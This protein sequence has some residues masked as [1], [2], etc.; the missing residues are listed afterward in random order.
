MIYKLVVPGPVTDVEEVRILEWHAVIGEEI[1]ANALLV[2][3]ETHK[4]VVEVR[5][6]RSG[7]LRASLCQE[8]DWRRLGEPLAILSDTLDEPAPVD[9]E[10]LQAWPVDFELT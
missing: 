8:G 5:G 10:G 6:G 7:F 4:A 3:L 9:I 1:A 2:E